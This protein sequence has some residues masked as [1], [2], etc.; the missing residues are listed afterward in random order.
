MTDDE[1]LASVTAGELSQLRA[2][3]FFEA[4]AN[5][6]WHYWRYFLK[7]PASA[8]PVDPHVPRRDQRVT[9]RFSNRPSSFES[10]WFNIAN[11]S[12]PGLRV[13][14][15]TS[16]RNWGCTLSRRKPRVARV[17][18]SA[19]QW[20]GFKQCGA[21]SGRL[22]D[23]STHERDIKAQVFKS[24]NESLRGS[25]NW[26]RSSWIPSA[27]SILR[28]EVGGKERNHSDHCLTVT[29]VSAALA[30]LVASSVWC[31]SESADDGIHTPSH[32]FQLLLRVQNNSLRSGVSPH[33]SKIA[34][35]YQS[36]SPPNV[37]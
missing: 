6:R 36:R 18:A 32:Y 11:Q 13:F 14:L 29:I 21:T 19:P 3:D 25:M 10:L 30:S 27:S 5:R 17:Q 33:L 28:M 2:S 24:D 20:R 22:A 1:M 26:S 12:P 7:F 34:S 4:P 16:H 23:E 9:Y 35:R 8:V 37:K 31:N 15:M